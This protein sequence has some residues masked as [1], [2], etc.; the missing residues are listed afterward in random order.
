MS[1]NQKLI[2]LIIL[3]L[4]AI[5]VLSWFFRR[6]GFVGAGI[7]GFILGYFLGRKNS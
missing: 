6:W 2:A 7:G 4:V 5:A 1:R 3:I